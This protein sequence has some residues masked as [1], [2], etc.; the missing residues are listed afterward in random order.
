MKLKFLLQTT[1][2]ISS[3]ALLMPKLA[4]AGTAGSFYISASGGVFAPA[5]LSSTK[6]PS[7]IGFSIEDT[8]A[9]LELPE[10][11]NIK[12]KIKN[13]TEASLGLGWN[14]TEDLRVEL[15]YTKP[16]I[17][18]IKSNDTISGNV[19]ITNPLRGKLNAPG[20]LIINTKVKT[21][22][23]ALHLKAYYDALKFDDVKIYLGIG[24]GLAS[25][26]NKFTANATGKVTIAG[27]EFAKEVPSS[28]VSEP[29]PN[30]NLSWL[31]ALGAAYKVSDNID[32]SLEYNYKDYGKSHSIKKQ[33]I[34]F[35]AKHFKGHSLLAK[36]NFGF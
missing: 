23:H 34:Q 30:F 26:Q 2:L 10:S 7:P 13:A 21:D 16:F 18:N 32:L 9:N 20:I 22:I 8:T 27:K 25:I 19:I 24:A 14:A 33:G 6:L 1:A 17:Q 28:S 15:A 31:L 35:G 5:K 29:K 11:A 3:V 36:V 12:H 4:F